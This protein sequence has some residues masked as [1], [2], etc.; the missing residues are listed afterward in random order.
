MIF[1]DLLFELNEYIE[2]LL[3]M[4]FLDQSNVLTIMKVNE[5]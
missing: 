2:V 5:I 4:C 3:V 1:G